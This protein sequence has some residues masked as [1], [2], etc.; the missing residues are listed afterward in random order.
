VLDDSGCTR[1]CVASAGSVVGHGEAI[2]PHKARPLLSSRPHGR[3]GSPIEFRL[4]D[5]LLEVGRV[6]VALEGTGFWNGAFIVVVNA[7]CEIL[8]A[9]RACPT[10]QQLDASARRE[11]A[12]DP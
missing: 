6:R 4:P 7:L 11:P 3:P 1:A 2:P 5:P 10:G 8:A 9:V 12:A